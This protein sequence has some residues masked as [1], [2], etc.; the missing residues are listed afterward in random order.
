VSESNLGEVTE[1]AKRYLSRDLFKCIEIPSNDDGAPK[2]LVKNFVQALKD[3]RIFHILDI[4]K[5]KSI[6]QYEVAD[7]KFLENILIKEGEEHIR[8]YSASKVIR[9]IPDQ[10][11]RIYFRDQMDK[12]RAIA[13]LNKTR[14]SG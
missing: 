13:L 5:G 2:R 8:L 12:D 11:T 7:K 14:A 6:K 1:L 4:L 10:S 9:S 3:E